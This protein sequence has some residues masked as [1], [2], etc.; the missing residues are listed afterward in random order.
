M[1]KLY[2]VAPIEFEVLT[3]PISTGDGQFQTEMPFDGEWLGSPN[4]PAMTGFILDAGSGAGT[5]T[6]FQIR[7]VT[8][9]RDYFTTEPEFQVDDADASG[10]ALLTQGVLCTKPT[11]RQGDIVALDIDGIPGGADSGQLYVTMSAGF[12]R[13]VD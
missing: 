13:T 1:A 6:Q 10:R 9:G 7:N 5:A 11:F 3:N 4:G 2:Y 8:Q 12:W